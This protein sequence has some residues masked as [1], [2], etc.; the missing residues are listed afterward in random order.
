MVIVVVT[1][2][3]IPAPRGRPYQNWF[4]MMRMVPSV[5]EEAIRIVFAT[6]LGSRRN[7]NSPIDITKMP[8]YT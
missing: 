4:C 3:G 7:I 8:A 6:S 5:A 2:S 1:G